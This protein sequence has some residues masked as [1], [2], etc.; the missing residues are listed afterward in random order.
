L[1]SII[2][3]ICLEKLVHSHSILS[4]NN[5]FNIWMDNYYTDD[6]KSQ[7]VWSLKKNEFWG[8]NLCCCI[9]FGLKNV[10]LHTF[11]Y[12]DIWMD[13]IYNFLTFPIKL[14]ICLARN[15][16][17][18]ECLQQKR[19]IYLVLLFGHSLSFLYFSLPLWQKCKRIFE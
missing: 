7:C 18:K 3:Q 16:S 2:Q 15:R 17:K 13:R 1:P 11:D 6:C 10:I 8:G 14:P 9:G 4:S 5:W 12:I 19:K